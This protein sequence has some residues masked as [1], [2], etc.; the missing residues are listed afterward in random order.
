MSYKSVLVLLLG[1]VVFA[2]PTPGIAASSAT[3]N[4]RDQEQRIRRAPNAIP[5][6]Y[7]V[8]LADDEDGEV[9]GRDTEWVYSGRLKHIYRATVKGFS[10]RLPRAA[11]EKLAE[12]P[13]VL[14]IEEDSVVTIQ[15]TAT[16]WSLDRIDQALLPLD[17]FYNVAM[18][19]LGVAVHVLDTGIRT[20]HQEFG[21]RAYIGGDYI[22][23]DR[24]GDPND[25]GNDDGNPAEPDGADC[26]GHGTHVAGSIGGFKYGVAKNVTLYGHRVLACDGSGTVSGIIAAIDRVTANSPR[27]AIVNMSL[28]GG[29]SDALDTAVRRSIVEGIV[30]VIAAGNSNV[31]AS[32]TSPARVSEAIT[33]GA[34]DRYDARASFSNYGPVLDLFAPGVAIDSAYYTADNHYARMSGTSMATP[35]VAGAAALYLE[36]HPTSSPEQVRNA[37][38]AAATANVLTSIGTGSPDRLLFAGSNPSRYS[39]TVSVNGTGAGTVTS[40][41]SGISCPGVCGA[42]FDSGI[43]LTLTAIADSS[44]T[45]TGWSVACTGTSDCI[46]TMNDAKSVTAAF[47]TIQPDLVSAVGT[48]PLAAAPATS[49]SFPETPTNRGGG[50]AA[51]STTRYYLSTDVLKSAGDIALGSRSITTLV[52]SA[53]SP[54]TVTFT[55]PSGTPLGNY[56]VIACADDYLKVAEADEVNNCGASASTV[57]VTR[58][59]LIVTAVGN[60]PASVAPGGTVHNHRHRGQSGRLHVRFLGNSLLSVG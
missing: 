12:D 21:G 7:I 9:V 31:D 48:V 24:D 47:A 35:H 40:Q 16:S 44:S 45:F 38:V 51:A 49:L 3:A 54:A 37:L 10:I 6:S 23:D 18:S 20:T 11:A 13:R 30:H 8:V 36:Q 19:G 28:G 2:S 34:T 22:D 17:G 53:T 39:L 41:P 1:T 27:P 25:I 56:F 60:P 52:A 5:D 4:S 57:A 58:P 32:N 46:V 14:F 26:H 43:A 33:V 50:D 29:V 55:V 59:D 15:Q 42:T